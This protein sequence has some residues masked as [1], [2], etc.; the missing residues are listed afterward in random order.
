MCK[1]YVGITGIT[2][3]AQTYAIDRMLEALDWPVSHQVM[4][5]VLVS[6]WTLQGMVPTN[7][8]QYPPADEVGSLLSRHPQSLNL[9]HYNDGRRPYALDMQLAS[10]KRLAPGFDGVQLNFAWP[11]PIELRRAE[12]SGGAIILQV[13]SK[14]LREAGRDMTAQWLRA[15]GGAVD[16]VLVDLSGGTGKSLDVTDTLRLLE[17]LTAVSDHYRLGLEFGVAGGL[18]AERI[19]S[20]A[21]LLRRF[22]C[23]SWD[24]QA[25]L[26]DAADELDLDLVQRY[27]AASLQL[28]RTATA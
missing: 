26:R 24:A 1:P 7:T 4:Y 16:Y 5:G 3:P 14:A 12:A 9:I 13:G 6:G 2:R 22:P 11:N 17:D 25:G 27:L 23:L 20:L 15:Y 8:R 28:I 18:S 19:P 10:L 21:L